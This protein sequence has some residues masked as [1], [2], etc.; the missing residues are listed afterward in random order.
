MSR[1]LIGGHWLSDK[2]A[3]A[4]MPSGA[5]AEEKADL[6]GSVADIQLTTE[7]ATAQPH[8]GPLEPPSTEQSSRPE[9]AQ[10]AVA[11]AGSANIE[12]VTKGSH[13]AE[14]EAL[15]SGDPD[16]STD[17]HQTGIQHA[18]PKECEDKD[19]RSGTLLYAVEMG[20]PHDVERLLK[21]GWWVDDEENLDRT[22]LYTAAMSERSPATCLYFS[23]V[24]C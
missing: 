1:H 23:V 2:A 12:A 4:G 24:M 17:M 16:G 8:G 22:P 13:S 21:A 11:P 3:D 10:A 15:T 7:P 14:S 5:E 20:K 6:L 19:D 18:G 9:A